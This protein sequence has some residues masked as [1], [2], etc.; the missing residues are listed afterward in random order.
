MRLRDIAITEREDFFSRMAGW[1]ALYRK[2]V[3]AIALI[4]GAALH[5][6]NGKTGVK[7]FDVCTFYYT[8]PEKAW[9]AKPVKVRDFGASKFG[10]HPDFD[11]FVG[12]KVDLMGRSVSVKPGSDPAAAIRAYMAEGHVGSSPWYWRQKPV[13]L[14]D[15][16]D[17]LQEIVWPLK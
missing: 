15:P 14:L 2:R 5:F 10:R 11:E 8:H 7:D 1:K 12:R 4:Q 17:R 9:Y 13:V 3:M 6:I 16:L